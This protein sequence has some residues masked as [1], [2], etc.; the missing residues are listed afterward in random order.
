MNK[1]LVALA[2]GSLMVILGLMYL[3]NQT[4]MQQCL[5]NHSEDTCASVLR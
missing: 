4:A 5:L 2:V 1:L 3:D